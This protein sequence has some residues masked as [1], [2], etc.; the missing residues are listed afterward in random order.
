MPRLINWRGTESKDKT[1]Y[2]V[3]IAGAVSNNPLLCFIASACR[4]SCRTLLV[5]TVDT[6]DVDNDKNSL[7]SRGSRFRV[8]KM[9]V[10]VC[11]FTMGPEPT[12][13]VLPSTDSSGSG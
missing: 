1:F 4:G 11:P 9:D 10:S 5:G 2:P 3:V 13:T 12:G 7:R 6:V 8:G